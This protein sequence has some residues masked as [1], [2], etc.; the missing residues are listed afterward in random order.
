MTSARVVRIACCAMRGEAR[1]NYARRHSQYASHITGSVSWIRLISRGIRTHHADEPEDAAH[2]ELA[3]D[4]AEEERQ[5]APVEA[6]PAQ[7]Q[8]NQLRHPAQEDAE[9]HPVDRSA[10]EADRVADRVQRPPREAQ[11][12]P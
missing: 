11:P 2:G 5:R 7:P 9:P 6:H 8:E 12:Q 4:E 10:G 3:E 1:T